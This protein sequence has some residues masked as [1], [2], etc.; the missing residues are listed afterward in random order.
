LAVAADRESQKIGIGD[1]LVTL[2]PS[3][4]L[5]DCLFQ[6]EIVR[7]EFVSGM[8]EVELQQFYWLRDTESIG[9]ES[10]L[11]TSRMKPFCVIGQVA[12]PLLA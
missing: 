9:A 2:K 1:P 11:V 8:R 12:Q 10:G 6:A 5:R 4:G 7:P 3:T